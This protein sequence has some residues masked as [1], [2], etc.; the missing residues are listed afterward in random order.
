MRVQDWISGRT[1][2]R[3]G[4]WIGRHMPRWVGYGLARLVADAFVVG[5]P[6][7]YRKVLANQVY[8]LGSE[9]SERERRRVAVRWVV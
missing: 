8:V 7:V 6:R 1:A 5:Q 9:T 4:L 2:V 3:L